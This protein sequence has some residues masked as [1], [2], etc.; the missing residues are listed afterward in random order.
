MGEMLSEFKHS[1]GMRK[2]AEIDTKTFII[3]IAGLDVS[4]VCTTL[5]HG[6]SSWF[7][8]IS[9]SAIAASVITLI[10]LVPKNEEDGG[11]SALQG[12]AHRQI[13]FPKHSATLA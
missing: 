1:Y 12:Q 13:I 11:R 6:G 5:V 2:D 10:G 9:R 8:W 4:S 3:I 7:L